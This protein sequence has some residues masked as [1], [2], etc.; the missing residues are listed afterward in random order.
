M[1]LELAFHFKQFLTGTLQVEHLNKYLWHTGDYRLNLISICSMSYS[2]QTTQNDQFGNASMRMQH[3]VMYTGHLNCV[4]KVEQT[5]ALVKH[6]TLWPA[7]RGLR[8]KPL[9]AGLLFIVVLS[10]P[11]Q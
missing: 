11:D 9:T 1:V 10:K 3:N 5:G 6:R 8:F 2:A 4:S 7:P